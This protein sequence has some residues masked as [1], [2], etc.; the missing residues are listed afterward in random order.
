[1]TNE[2][3]EEDGRGIEIPKINVDIIEAIRELKV[4]TENQRM[5]IIG[6]T[7]KFNSDICQRLLTPER[8]RKI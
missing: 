4:Q 8:N 7:A 5:N 2:N 1:M 6:K 3:S